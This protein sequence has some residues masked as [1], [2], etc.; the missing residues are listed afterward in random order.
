MKRLVAL[1]LVLSLVSCGGMN[2]VFA[3]EGTYTITAAELDALEQGIQ[4]LAACEQTTPSVDVLGS[5][6]VTVG[7]RG[8]IATS[9][10][11]ELRVSLPS[12]VGPGTI[13][14]WTIPVDLNLS[15]TA[16]QVEPSWWEAHD[17]QIGVTIG[18]VTVGASLLFL[19]GALQ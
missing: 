15:V 8:Q 10:R 5:P 3:A 18:G 16:E 11:L 19:L 2:P 17:F 14:D 13:Y 6:F 7:P 9:G 12:T 1:A 4:D